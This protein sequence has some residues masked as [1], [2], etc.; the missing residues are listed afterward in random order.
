MKSIKKILQISLVILL[1]FTFIIG[2]TKPNI[3]NAANYYDSIS[4]TLKGDSLKSALR[5]LIT[6]THT[7]KSSY[8]DCRN[9]QIVE[10]TDGDPN[11]SG[12][13]ILFWSNLSIDSTW[14]GGTSWN[15]EHVWPKSHGGFGEKGAGADLHHIRPT[16]PRVNSVHNNHPYGVVSNGEF[17]YTSDAN[18]NVYTEAKYANSTFEPGDSKKGDT[19]RI[20]FYLLVRYSELESKD[21]TGV[22]PGIETL[23]EW[24]A[25]DPVDESE[26]R[27]NDAVQ[28]IQGNRNPFI[29][30]SNY[31]NLIWD[32]DAEIVTNYYSVNVKYDNLKCNT[33]IAGTSDGNGKYAGN[34][35]VTVYPY[36]GYECIGIKDA[37]TGNNLT[38]N[39]TYTIANINK[40]YN[41][42]VIIKETS[43]SGDGGGDNTGGT[44]TPD[45][46]P[47]TNTYTLVKDPALLTVGSQIII[48]ATSYDVALSTTQNNNNRAETIIA[49]IGDTIEVTD[50][51]QILTIEQGIS[52]LALNTGNGYLYA[53]SS[54]KNYLKTQTTLND[55]GNWLIT[56]D[57]TTGAATIIAQGSNTHNSLRYNSS[58]NLFSCYESGQEDVSI[59]IKMSSETEKTPF[60]EATSTFK[61]LDTK[62]SLFMNYQKT[63]NV[64]GGISKIYDFS[65]TKDNK[66]TEK[67]TKTLG[68]LSWMLSTDA[69]F[70]GYDTNTTNKGQQVGS[71]NNPAS[72]A[73]FTSSDYLCDI[74]S[75][76]INTS[77]AK[78]ISCTLKVYVG[79]TQIGDDITLTAT[80]TEYIIESETPLSG[81]VKLEYTNASKKAIYI[82]SI[83]FNYIEKTIDTTY[84][85]TNASIRFGT[86]LNK[87]LYDVFNQKGA[88]WGVEYKVGSASTWTSAICTPARVN[89]TDNTIVDENG[90]YYQFAVVFKN[91]NYSHLDT[92]I[93]ARVY[94][95]IDG[96]TYYMNSASYSL[97][98]L[99]DVYLV[100]DDT[101]SYTEHLAMLEHLKNY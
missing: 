23:L 92:V 29:D 20:F 84:N 100:S 74:T 42:E 61:L 94:V 12:N 39:S 17:V 97:R 34:V 21:L 56:I 43:S 25:M 67:G 8:D 82:K 62:A 81:N 79:E 35:K 44:T 77:G 6:D 7:Y 22:T 53:A 13:I 19:A 95:T 87:E 37:S 88:V 76:K 10:K 64:S 5:T 71:G 66:F 15:R 89:G 27:R 4:T 93:S 28:E 69:G 83:N 3:V 33:V 9:P 101:S 86:V 59:Y 46:T 16:D 36:E 1:M 49:K 60:E 58:N 80:A 26:I 90:N 91:L 51:T 2:L 63:T 18:G 45:V 85:L 55:N 11:K 73:I 31:A 78:S 40:N 54:T 41:L 47:S 70:F 57:P 24:N 72:Y 14:D 32:P 96:V 98:T 75:I 99:V 30:N 65:F 68:N 48:V 38:T 50:T 52:G